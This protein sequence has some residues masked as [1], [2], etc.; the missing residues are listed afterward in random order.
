MEQNEIKA[1]EKELKEVPLAFVFDFETG[2]LDC[3][4]HAATQIAVHAVRLDTFENVGRYVKYIRPYNKIEGSK[5]KKKTLKTKQEIAEEN[6]QLIEYTEKALEYSAITME[7]LENEGEDIKVVAEGLIAFIESFP[8]CKSKANKPFFAGQ[9][10][11]FDMGFLQHLLVYGGC[12]KNISK[13][14]NGS[15]DFFGNFQPHYIDTITLAK[16]AMCHQDPTPSYKL[17]L[18][19]EALGIELVDAHDADA[20]V[21][22]TA[23]VMR[24]C[25]SRM[26]DESIACGGTTQGEKTRKH[27]KI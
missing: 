21:G 20:D 27:F 10:V 11:Q 17:E 1:E 15:V 18:I 12:Y 16:M 9:N 2:G 8:Q 14:V 24:I 25:A 7:M 22:A 26:R 23:G 4:V 5:P 3:Q 13:L 19:C 6:E